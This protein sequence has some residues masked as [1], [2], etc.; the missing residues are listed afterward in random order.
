MRCGVGLCGHCQLGPT[1]ICRDGPVY[2][3][4]EIE[5]LLEGGGSYEPVAPQ[6]RQAQGLEREPADALGLEVLLLRRLPALAAR[7]RGRAAR[8]HRRGR[9]RLLPRGDERDRE[10]PVRPDARRGLDHDAA[11]RRANPRD[12]ARL[13]AR[14]SRSAP[15]RRAAGSRRCGTSRSVAE[16]VSAVYASPEYIST[17]RTSTAIADHVHVDFELQGCPINKHQLLEV[18][19]AFLAG[20]RPNVPS[21]PR[22]RRVQARR[23]SRA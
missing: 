18:V 12:P 16:F 15:A 19:G 3:W 8:A 14:S 13:E 17:L 6:R 7:L 11:R 23:R 4:D 5:P 9:D 21:H 10:G 1:L 20:R 2:R 22:L